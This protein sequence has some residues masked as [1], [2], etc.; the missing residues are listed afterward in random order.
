[1]NSIADTAVYADILIFKTS[2]KNNSNIN[3]LKP[4]IDKIVKDGRWNFDLEDCDKIFRVET[5][6]NIGAQ[7]ISLF[8]INGFNCEELED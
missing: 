4:F 6:R 8:N 1:M 2:I 7:L 5:S 3:K